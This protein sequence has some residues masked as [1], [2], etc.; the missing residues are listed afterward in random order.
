VA[1]ATVGLALAHVWPPLAQEKEAFLVVV[2]SSIGVLLIEIR[3]RVQPTGYG[4][5]EIV[6]YRTMREARTLILDLMTAEICRNENTE[7]VV[8]GGRL[9]S[10]VEI[11]RELDDRLTDCRASQ[12]TRIEVHLLDPA[13]LPAMMLPGQLNA[14][15]QRVRNEAIEAQVVACIHELRKISLDDNFRRNHVQIDVVYYREIPST[16]YFII[17]NDNLLFGGFVWDHATADMDGP[18]SPCWYISAAHPAFD[19]I[20]AWLWNRA[21]LGVAQ[22]SSTGESVAGAAEG[23]DPAAE[24]AASPAPMT[25]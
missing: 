7:I 4:G 16:Y 2:L 24:A 17:G 22:A 11:L 12:L 1:G 13:F 25:R 3:S 8:R 6:T 15:D 9:R 21:Q 5:V 19:S 14:Q 10:I 18:A 20:R 23:P